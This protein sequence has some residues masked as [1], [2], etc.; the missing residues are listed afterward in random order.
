[1][2]NK[3]DLTLDLD[4]RWYTTLMYA[5]E[6]VIDDYIEI[7]KNGELSSDNLYSLEWEI[8]T[9]KGVFSQGV[10]PDPEFGR[11][12]RRYEKALNKFRNDLEKKL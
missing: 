5:M 7:I 8:E 9:Y 2:K 10:L 4:F 6:N 3:A 11:N 1:M 12:V